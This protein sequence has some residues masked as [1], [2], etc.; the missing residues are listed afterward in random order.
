MDYHGAGPHQRQQ[1]TIFV[2]H[3]WDSWITDCSADV[4]LLHKE[5]IYK[6]LPEV[7]GNEAN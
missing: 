4:F 7:Y 5:S 3:L 6:N 1:M 2:K